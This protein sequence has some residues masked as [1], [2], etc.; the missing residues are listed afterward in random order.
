MTMFKAEKQF[1]AR[2]KPQIVRPGFPAILQKL[3]NKIQA[4]SKLAK[5][6]EFIVGLK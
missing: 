4:D 1:D 6:C 5:L 3:K 2:N